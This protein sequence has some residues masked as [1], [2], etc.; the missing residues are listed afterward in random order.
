MRRC[1]F[2]LIELLVVIAIIAL[3]IGILLPALSAARGSARRV[4]CTTNH[5]TLMRASHMYGNDWRDAIPD[6][7]W[8]EGGPAQARYADGTYRRGWLLHPI[9][10]DIALGNRAIT[11]EHPLY[12]RKGPE[13]GV[14]WDYLDGPQPTVSFSGRWTQNDPN[15]NE[16][17]SRIRMWARQESVGANSDVAMMYRCPEDFAEDEWRG[18]QNLTSYLMNGAVRAF[19]ARDDSYTIDQMRGDSIIFWGNESRLPDG[20]I[21]P[22]GWNDGSSWPSENNT[23]LAARH[24]KGA[25]VGVVDGSTTF[26]TDQQFEQW[27]FRTGETPGQFRPNPLWCDPQ[28]P[29]GGNRPG[30]QP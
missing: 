2:T 15:F 9:L 22:A 16:I 10:W 20:T 25:P 1:G 7:N 29:E 19:G 17:F 30:W 11:G 6:P 24:G 13:S 18:T 21:D 27:T 4:V 5:R 28:H 26:I 14:L 3:L 23:G 12:P 8:G